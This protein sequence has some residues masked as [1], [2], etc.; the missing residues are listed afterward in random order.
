LIKTS[1]TSGSCSWL[2][3]PRSVFVRFGVL[4]SAE[5]IAS[6]Q[7]KRRPQQFHAGSIMGSDN[8]LLARSFI[9]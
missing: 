5:G 3:D 7:L 4:S 6:I 8:A 1:V 2:P 9:C